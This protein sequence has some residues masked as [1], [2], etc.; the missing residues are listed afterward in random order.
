[1]AQESQYRFQ[2]ATELWRLTDN[3]AGLSIDNPFQLNRGYAH[4]D[5]SH[6]S[7]D[8]HR[9]QDGG[10]RNMLAFDTERYQSI[11]KYL[12]AYGRFTFGMDRTKE[13]AW[14][15][16]W[17]PFSGSP[18]YTGSSIKGKYDTQ[19]FDLTAAIGTMPI[20]QNVCG[21]VG[22]LT[23]GA[24]LDYKVGDQSRLRDPRSRNELLQ[25]RVTPSLAYTFGYGDDYTVGL[26][27]HYDR[28]KRSCLGWSPCRKTP[29]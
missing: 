2:D 17:D 28:R 20:R 19:L 16:L 13:R 24:R 11:G 18:F 26:S 25:Y 12:K 1:M 3:A 21:P 6:R 14:A 8:Y 10:Q 22:K 5:L 23:L 15:D 9:V 7:G 29:I 4:F 27:G